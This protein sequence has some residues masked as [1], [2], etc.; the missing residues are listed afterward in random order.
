M[1][2]YNPK[3][4]RDEP[5]KDKSVEV[6]YNKMALASLV[7]KANA[8]AQTMDPPFRVVGPVPVRV[9]EGSEINYGRALSERITVPVSQEYLAQ[10]TQLASLQGSPLQTWLTS[11]AKKP[12][13]YYAPHYD[14]SIPTLAGKT[15]NPYHKNTY[16]SVIEN[17]LNVDDIVAP[18]NV[19][20]LIDGIIILHATRKLGHQFLMGLTS[21][22]GDLIYKG[23]EPDRTSHEGVVIRNDQFGNYPFK[24]TG[25]FIVTGMYGNFGAAAQVTEATIRKM[26]RESITRTYLSM[27]PRKR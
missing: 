18:E 22:F 23:I 16:V 21:D 17:G 27:L 20:T 1:E 24:I 14:V 13:Q 19:R 9:S 10:D 6:P 4:D 11:I 26:V 25:E 7:E 8:V 2:G 3:K 15:I 12:A 5:T